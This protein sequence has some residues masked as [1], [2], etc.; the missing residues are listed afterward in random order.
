[1]RVT[2]SV[3]SAVARLRRIST[4]RVAAVEPSSQTVTVNMSTSL[5]FSTSAITE[6]PTSMSPFRL[7]RMLGVLR[8]VIAE[9][10]SQELQHGNQDWPH[11]GD[12]AMKLVADLARDHCN[13]AAR[14]GSLTWHHIL[15]EEV[16][17]AW[18]EEDWP[19]AREEWVQVAAVAV[20][21]IENGDQRY[22]QQVIAPG[23]GREAATKEADGCRD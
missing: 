5:P 6:L 19:T 20:A 1:M 4:G 21:A 13:A 17:E 23:I 2:S 7:A 10:G 16:N 8:D 18:A 12:A 9:R 3:A 22:A 14:D 11:G 15:R